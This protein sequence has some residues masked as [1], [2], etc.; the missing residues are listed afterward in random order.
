MN[1]VVKT[2][3]M[4]LRMLSDEE[5]KKLISEE[6]DPEM[7]QAYTEMYTGCVENPNQRPWYAIWLMELEDKTRVGDFCFKGLNS[8]GSVEIGYGVIPEYWG[9]G[10]ATEMVEAITKWALSQPGVSR[11]EAETDL[12][13]LASQRVLEKAGFIPNGIIGEEGPRFVLVH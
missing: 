9:N 4:S 1:Q 12:N 5:M 7:I 10:Y 6:K 8:D 3:R 2:K 11:I 13:N